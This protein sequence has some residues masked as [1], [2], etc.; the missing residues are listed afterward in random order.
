MASYKYKQEYDLPIRVGDKVQ[1]KSSL[2]TFT[3]QAIEYTKTYTL[4]VGCLDQDLEDIQDV[5]LE[6]PE[7]RIAAAVRGRLMST[8]WRKL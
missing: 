2:K 6:G 7:T 5:T 4:M 8:Y 3:I 1:C